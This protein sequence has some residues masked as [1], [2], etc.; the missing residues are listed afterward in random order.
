M[1]NSTVTNAMNL[2]F[3]NCKYHYLINVYWAWTKLCFD[4]MCVCRVFDF[5]FQCEILSVLF[6]YHLLCSRF[7]LVSFHSRSLACIAFRSLIFSCW[8]LL[9][10]CCLFLSSV[11]SLFPINR[12]SSSVQS[13][14][15]SLENLFSTPSK[16]VK[17]ETS[18]LFSPSSLPE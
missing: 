17:K 11:R 13:K 6:H 3:V 5:L 16:A 9:D 12:S 18:P 2:V 15:F 4:R 8:Y 7:I 14:R 10:W 1:K